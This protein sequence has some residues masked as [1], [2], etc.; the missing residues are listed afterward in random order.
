MTKNP[1]ITL[2]KSK[3][4]FKKSK[5]QHILNS[6]KTIQRIV[7][8]AGIFPSD[9]VLEIGPGTGNLTLPLL[10]KAKRVVAVEI[11][12]RLML[13][14]RKRLLGTFLAPKP[15]LTELEPIFIL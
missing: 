5:G 13:E 15:L 14:L 9:V 11:D 2:S 1:S 8:K 7:D 3:I 4:L 10:E 12:E 6:R